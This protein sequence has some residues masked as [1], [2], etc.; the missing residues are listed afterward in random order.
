MKVVVGILGI[1]VTIVAGIVTLYRFQELWIEYRTTAESLKHEKYLFATRIAPY[2]IDE[3]FPLLVERI[4][5][6][7]SKEHTK[8]TRHMKRSQAE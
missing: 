2:D 5:G 1:V 7:I 3:P 8:W 6:L 4:E